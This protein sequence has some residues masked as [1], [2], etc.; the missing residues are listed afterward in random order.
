ML[1]T[2]VAPLHVYS[3]GCVFIENIIDMPPECSHS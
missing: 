3:V 2:D 1:H